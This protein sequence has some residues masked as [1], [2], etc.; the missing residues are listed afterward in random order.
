[1][2]ALQFM[3]KLCWL[4][5]PVAVSNMAPV[6]CKNQLQFLAV[7][8]DGGRVFHGKALFGDHKTWR[9]I[10]VAT[11]TGGLVFALQVWLTRQFPSVSQWSFFDISQAPLWFGFAF[12]FAAIFGDLVKSFFKRR[13]DI[14]PGDTWFPFDQVDLVVFS[15][16]VAALVFPLTWQ[17]VAAAF[18]T[19]I[20]LHVVVNRIGFWLHIKDTPW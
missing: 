3:L 18:F 16:L 19:G 7:P 1:M 5:L 6:L 9:G 2:G 12:G 17:I 4:Y 11:L 10:V 20:V 8:V 15:T 14:A 13:V